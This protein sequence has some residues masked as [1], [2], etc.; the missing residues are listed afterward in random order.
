MQDADPAEPVSRGDVI[1]AFVS[2]LQAPK[3]FVQQQTADF[4]RMRGFNTICGDARR[5]ELWFSSNCGGKD[6]VRLEAGLHAVS[7]GPLADEW[8]KMRR[9]K[10]RIAPLLDTI[11]AEGVHQ[12]GKTSWTIAAL[13]RPANALHRVFALA[14]PDC[15]Q[16]SL[17]RAPFPVGRQ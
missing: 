6:A 15:C 13:A 1:P 8:P 10:E 2:S 7:N 12:I 3:D 16:L 14:E 11:D 9:G 4:A 5:K 17:W